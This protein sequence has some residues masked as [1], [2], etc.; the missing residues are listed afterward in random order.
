MHHMQACV[1]YAVQTH[2][3]S[4]HAPLSIPSSNAGLPAP[5]LPRV[6]RR[7][8]SAARPLHLSW[9]HSKHT[10]TNK[11][12]YQLRLF[13]ESFGVRT[14]LL[15]AE[16]PLNSR[17]HILSTFNKGLFD[18]LIATDDVH[19]AAHDA[20]AA[21]AQGKCIPS[22]TIYTEQEGSVRLQRRKRRVSKK[23]SC[24]PLASREIDGGGVLWTPAVSGAESW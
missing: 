19:A 9:A 18:F 13:L 16:L 23:F 5:P 10:Y 17:S 11:Q 12:G 8:D 24:G 6:L 21:Q 1:A 2:T 20:G 7:A 15:N 14:A 3:H 4:H 22:Y